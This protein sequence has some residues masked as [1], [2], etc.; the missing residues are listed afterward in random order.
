MK[1]TLLSIPPGP[2]ISRRA[3]NKSAV[4]AAILGCTQGVFADLTSAKN[5]ASISADG[6]LRYTDD[7]LVEIYSGT[8]HA[9]PYGD[10]CAVNIVCQILGL[11]DGYYRLNVGNNPSH[12]PGVL[13][14]FSNHLSFS[15]EKTNKVAAQ[16]LAVEMKRAGQSSITKKV[17]IVKGL[18]SHETHNLIN[19]INGNGLIVAVGEII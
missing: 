12:L 10:G 19:R 18:V 13:K 7:G 9:L 15:N 6:L 8:G 5:L 3:F 17:V 14:Q 11:K 1:H 4:L 16:L 2:A